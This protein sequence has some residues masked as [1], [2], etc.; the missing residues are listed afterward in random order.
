MFIMTSKFQT[1]F[2]ILCILDLCLETKNLEED[3]KKSENCPEV[4]T[5]LVS[6]I[7]PPQTVLVTM[8]GCT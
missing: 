7:F 2:T 1:L 4:K 8:T 5:V 3:T 6:K